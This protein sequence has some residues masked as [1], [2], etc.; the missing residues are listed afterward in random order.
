MGALQYAGSTSEGQAQG[1]T[2]KYTVD[3]VSDTVL[4]NLDSLRENVAAAVKDR[5]TKEYI[6]SQDARFAPLSEYQT[7]DLARNVPKSLLNAPGGP[8]S[9]PLAP[10]RFPPLGAGYVMGPYG[11][12]G[13]D[14]PTVGLTPTIVASLATDPIPTGK[15]FW[16]LCFG[17]I[18]VQCEDT[19]GLPLVE[20]RSESG[21]LLAS[22]HG[23]T[24]FSGPQGVTAMPVADTGNWITSTGGPFRV[25]MNLSDP[26][27]RGVRS[28][29]D[30]AAAI[31]G[32]VYILMA[33]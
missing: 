20:I 7:K 15:K 33:S 22:G 5:V 26:N 30:T 14:T 24:M 21:L 4:P 2:A 32:A 9:L 16:P 27:D 28:S 1:I 10:A 18:M 25:S 3:S 8:T 23:R 6:D 12:Q 19:G 11:W 31:G 29:V 17:Q 13:I